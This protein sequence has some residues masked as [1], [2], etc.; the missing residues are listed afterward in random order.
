M[1]TTGSISGKRCFEFDVP[2]ARYPPLPPSLSL[3]H[4]LALA[5]P[6]L[7]VG[8][9]ACGTSLMEDRFHGGGC[10]YGDSATLSRE[11]RGNSGA[12]SRRAAAFSSSSSSLPCI[13]RARLS[14]Q[15]FA[16]RSVPR[17]RNAVPQSQ[18]SPPSSSS[19]SLPSSSSSSRNRHRR[20]HPRTVR[21]RPLGCGASVSEFVTHAR[22]HLASLR[23]SEEVDGSRSSG[24][25]ASQPAS[26]RASEAEPSRASAQGLH[27]S[28]SCLPS[29]HP[30][31]YCAPFPLLR[32]HRS[33][34]P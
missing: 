30:T 25:P 24:Q 33:R 28:N 3:F 9:R 19:S 32:S 6:R 22:T 23:L 4:A 7:R 14:Q 5:L 31:S 16:L 29:A 27:L 21:R 15:H 26:E 11:H 18:S 8:G 10:S 20:C 17:I 34:L 1:T 13:I 12:R 2:S